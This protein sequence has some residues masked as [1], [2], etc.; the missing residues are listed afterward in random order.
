MSNFF[1]SRPIFLGDCAVRGRAGL[2]LLTQLPIAQYPT[3]APPT[4]VLNASY[5]GAS[6]ETLKNSVISVIEQQM[7]GATGLMYME[8]VARRR[9]RHPHPEL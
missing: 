3:V 5:P 6:A 2:C 8:S 9:H 1:I 4:I 7:N